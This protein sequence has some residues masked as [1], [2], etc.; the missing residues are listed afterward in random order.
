MN[1]GNR[2]FQ[3]TLMKAHHMKYVKIVSLCIYTMAISGLINP[4]NIFSAEMK[5]DEN[6]VPL[7]EA[8]AKTMLN[9]Y[10]ALTALFVIKGASEWQEL[11]I[12][13]P[14]A[15]EM[16]T[17]IM[18]NRNRFNN[19]AFSTDTQ[20]A[21]MQ[22]N[23]A[24]SWQKLKN[25]KKAFTSSLNTENMS[26]LEIMHNPHNFF[27]QT[28]FF[29]KYKSLYNG[30]QIQK[31]IQSLLDQANEWQE[32]F[33][34]TP[35]AI[36]VSPTITRARSRDNSYSTTITSQEFYLKPDKSKELEEQF[37][38]EKSTMQIDIEKP[39]G[40]EFRAREYH[41]AMKDTLSTGRLSSFQKFY[42]AMLSTAIQR[43]IEIPNDLR[44]RYAVYTK[45]IETLET[46]E[47][48]YQAN[49]L[50]AWKDKKAADEKAAKEEAEEAAAE[51]ATEAT[52]RNLEIQNLSQL[53]NFSNSH[54]DMMLLF[55][56]EFAPLQRKLANVSAS[57][58]GQKLLNIIH[59]AC[60][61]PEEFKKT[62][63]ALPKSISYEFNASEEYA[64][65]FSTIKEAANGKETI[66]PE[67]FPNS[68]LAKINP[69]NVQEFLLIKNNNEAY[70]CVMLNASYHEMN[71]LAA[72]LQK[73]EYTSSASASFGTGTG[74]SL[75]TILYDT[76]FIS[77][78]DYSMTCIELTEN[79]E[80]GDGKILLDTAFEL[81]QLRGFE[82]TKE[83]CS[84]FISNTKKFISG[85]VVVPQPWM[86][87]LKH[88]LIQNKQITL[89]TT[90]DLQN[91]STIT[92]N[93]RTAN[94]LIKPFLEP[95]DLLNAIKGDSTIVGDTYNGKSVWVQPNIWYYFTI[96]EKTEDTD[97]WKF[98]SQQASSQP[99][100]P[101]ISS[102]VLMGLQTEL[103]LNLNT[104]SRVTVVSEK[105]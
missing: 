34:N 16:Y 76:T 100:K 36:K 98:P 102:D 14:T 90:P 27:Y 103:A 42:E 81:A 68:S 87:K 12:T 69:T 64:R 54:K 33:T 74:L 65:F 28:P 8:D 43:A 94:I 71:K 91:I 24:V 38:Q 6:G 60:N 1:V 52:Q 72:K 45:I 57:P 35:S 53:E 99:Q 58:E 73:Y 86:Q 77:L 21:A 75:K 25:I 29:V 40:S 59:M 78:K 95:K 70:H 47:L 10:T 63:D 62:V 32:S 5:V 20:E 30:S 31:K 4:L 22:A 93:F 79:N 18:G 101:F 7:T 66:L 80:I 55:N 56:A 48:T 104:L 39:I 97:L 84:Y 26:D 46:I 89:H 41:S 9:D 96:P 105:K 11:E 15:V 3:F 61:E 17:K 92:H 85:R 23:I 37:E 51:A 88:A 2:N 50:N 49:V 67:Y 19:P 44:N 83:T 13:A 82:G